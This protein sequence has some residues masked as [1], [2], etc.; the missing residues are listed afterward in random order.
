MGYNRLFILVEGD[1]DARFVERVIKPLLTDRYND[2]RLWQYSR[3]KKEKTGNFLR[4]ISQMGADYIFIR[5]INS[6]P[7]IDG[8]KE[9]ILHA[10]PHVI[11]ARR[12]QITVKEIE[13]WYLA[14]LCD[15][16]CGRLARTIV[17]NTDLLT[18]EQ[19]DSL[20]PSQYDSR[21]HFMQ[22]ILNHFSIEV[23]M[24]K[25]KSFKYFMERFIMQ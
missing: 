18:K 14:G 10:F 23:A 13:S 15:S 20:I 17:Q 8:R 1:D 24:R 19:F 9:A 6:S 7:C 12:I 22:D 4:S 16:D 21:I 2:V 25:N 3:Q 11:S 5:D